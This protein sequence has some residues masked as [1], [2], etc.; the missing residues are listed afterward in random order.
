MHI[1]TPATN[2]L[3]FGSLTLHIYGL[4]ILAGMILAVSLSLLR[5]RKLRAVEE[6][7]SLS[8]SDLLDIALITLPCGIV[9]ARVYYVVTVPKHYLEHPLDVFAINQ[10]GLGIMGGLIAGILAAVVVCR[11]KGLNL[12]HFAYCCVPTVPLAQAVGRLGNWFNGELYGFE[13]D[14]PWGLD[15]SRGQYLPTKFYHPTFLYEIIWDVIIFA[16]LLFIFNKRHYNS[17]V[18]AP[19]YLLLYTIGRSVVESFRIDYSEYFLGVR[20]NMWFSVTLMLLSICWLIALAAKSGRLAQFLG[21]GGSA[22]P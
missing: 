1:P 7:C 18:V 14:L 6:N 4:C 8:A 3:Q 21:R 20:V 22:Q 13:T 5:L 9:G 12:N 16:L 11:V 19:T 2:V 10:G 15:I 17:I